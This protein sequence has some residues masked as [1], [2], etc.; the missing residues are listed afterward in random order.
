MMVWAYRFYRINSEHYVRMITKSMFK[1]EG[2][3]LRNG[4]SLCIPYIMAINCPLIPASK[5]LS[6][7]FPID[8]P[9]L[10]PEP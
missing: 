10:S 8:S 3:G 6:S 9:T 4:L 5:T 2:S 7:F 1:V